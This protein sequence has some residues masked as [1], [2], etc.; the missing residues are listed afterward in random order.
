MQGVI[1]NVLINQ[2]KPTEAAARHTVPCST[3]KD[4]L[5]EQIIH[6]TKPGSKP[7]LTVTE[8]NELT[9]HL[10]DA[11]NMGYGKMFYP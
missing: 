11:A 3:L 2:L 9:S 10:I 5:R 6:G 4:R 7:Y 8:E 1:N